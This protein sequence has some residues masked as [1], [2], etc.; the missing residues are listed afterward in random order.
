MDEEFTELVLG[1]VE[2]VPP[3]QATTYGDIARFLGRGGPRQ[4]GQV[5]SRVGGSVAWWRVVR[6]D[7]RPVRGLEHEALARLQADGTP[8]RAERVDLALAR[9]PFEQGLDTDPADTP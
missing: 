8:L 5:M 7:G 4:V 6:A 1:A 2:R 9:Y 3:G